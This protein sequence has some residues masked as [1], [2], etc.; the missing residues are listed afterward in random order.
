MTNDIIKSDD[1][2]YFKWKNYNYWIKIHFIKLADVWSISLIRS[3]DGEESRGLLICYKAKK[4]DG[5]L[6][7]EFNIYFGLF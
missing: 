1:T 4:L 3:Y 7:R 2:N 5:P 6:M